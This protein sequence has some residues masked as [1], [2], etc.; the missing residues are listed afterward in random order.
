MRTHRRKK[1]ISADD[2]IRSQKAAHRATRRGDIAEAERWMRLAERQMRFWSDMMGA[3][4]SLDAAGTC[5]HCG[6]S[7]RAAA[8]GAGGRP[9]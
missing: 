2:F 9:C 3:V 6:R 7:T 4:D 8:G 1:L 5:P